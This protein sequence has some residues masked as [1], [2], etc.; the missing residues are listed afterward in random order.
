MEG[1]SRIGKT[2]KRTG[3]RRRYRQNCR[4]LDKNSSDS[5]TAKRVGK[6]DQTRGRV[7]SSCGRSKSCLKK[8]RQFYPQIPRRANRGK[9][10]DRFIFVPGS[11]RCRKNR[12]G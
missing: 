11:D 5:T 9:P 6:T 4:S 1:N 7:K 10:S 12:D 8:N 2:F 3:K